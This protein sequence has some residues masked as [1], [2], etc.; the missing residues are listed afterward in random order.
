MA[1]RHRV[2]ET[3]R[4]RYCTTYERCP[5]SRTSQRRPCRGSE[6]PAARA[7]MGEVHVCSYSTAR[8]AG[9]PSPCAHPC[10]RRLARPRRRASEGRGRTGGPARFQA[11]GTRAPPRAVCG[12]AQHSRRVCGREFYTGGARVRPGVRGPRQP[13]CT[14]TYHVGS[15]HHPPYSKS[16][17]VKTKVDPHGTGGM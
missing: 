7:A 9:R 17:I 11:C 12:D 10:G 5:R 13:H 4:A 1:P 8:S 15:R 16:N 2:W 3:N 6:R 14:A